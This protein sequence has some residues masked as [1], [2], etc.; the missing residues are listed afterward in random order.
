MAKD[1]LDNELHVGDKV[2]FMQ[3]NYRNFL[4]GIISRI[5]P[6]T[7]IVEHAKT[8]VCSESTKQDHNQVVRIP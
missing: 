4:I 6:K 2:I 7:L 5:T 1:F 3:K 8:N